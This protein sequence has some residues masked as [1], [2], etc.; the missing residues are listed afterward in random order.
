MKPLRSFASSSCN[1]HGDTCLLEREELCCYDQDECVWVCC[2]STRKDKA[3]GLASRVWEAWLSGQLQQRRDSSRWSRIVA[4]AVAFLSVWLCCGQPMV[5]EC[6]GGWW[7]CLAGVAFPWTRT[8]KQT[9]WSR[10]RTFSVPDSRGINKL[11][12]TDPPP[13]NLFISVSA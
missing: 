11:G 4:V 5:S 8:T 6:G 12:R 2:T 13:V 1:S 9:S 3:S 10:P 7:V